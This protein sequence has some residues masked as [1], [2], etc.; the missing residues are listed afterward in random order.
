MVAVVFQ[1]TDNLQELTEKGQHFATVTKCESD[2]V[3]KKTSHGLALTQVT[4]D[5]RTPLGRPL[6]GTQELTFNNQNAFDCLK[7]G[8]NLKAV[9]SLLKMGLMQIS[10]SCFKQCQHPMLKTRINVLCCFVN[11]W[12]IF[13]FMW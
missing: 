5:F 2:T 1:I 9:F 12:I 11:I 4:S 10:R 3:R 8:V 6:R 7:A 13:G